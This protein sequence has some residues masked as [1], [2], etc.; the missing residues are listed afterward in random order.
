[1]KIFRLTPDDAKKI[2]AS[3]PNARPRSIEGYRALLGEA[4]FLALE[5]RLDALTVK[6]F[7]QVR[8]DAAKLGLRIEQLVW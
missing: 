6:D 2:A 4:A 1:M 8:T 3:P 7:E 5:R